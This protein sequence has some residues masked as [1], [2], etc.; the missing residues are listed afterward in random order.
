M[1]ILQNS[2]YKSLRLFP[3][4]QTDQNIHLYLHHTVFPPFACLHTPKNTSPSKLHSP[5]STSSQNMSF[6]SQ[7]PHFCH[8]YQDCT[9]FYTS[10]NEHSSEDAWGNLSKSVDLCVTKRCRA[11]SNEWPLGKDAAEQP[12]HHQTVKRR[13]SR[14]EKEEENVGSPTSETYQLGP[15]RVT[16][17]HPG[18]ECHFTETAKQRRIYKSTSSLFVLQTQQMDSRLSHRLIQR[19]H[20]WFSRYPTVFKALLGRLLDETHL[21]DTLSSRD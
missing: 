12:D 15:L 5:I 21:K 17:S 1:A 9:V 3:S 16:N 14:E 10:H 7:K 2:K 13:E 19:L 8:A 4:D 6:F 18:D 20:G 11:L